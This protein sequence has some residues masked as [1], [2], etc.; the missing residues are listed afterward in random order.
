MPKFPFV[1]NQSKFSSVPFSK[2]VLFWELL[3]YISG[4][5][6]YIL[7]LQSCGRDFFSPLFEIWALFF[8]FCLA[9][10]NGLEVVH[11]YILV[12]HAVPGKKRLNLVP[13]LP[14][15]GKK[16]MAPGMGGS[17]RSLWVPLSPPFTM[18]TGAL[19][20]VKE[21][22]LQRPRD[23]TGIPG[24]FLTPQEAACRVSGFRPG[25][26]CDCGYC[27]LPSLSFPDSK[28]SGLN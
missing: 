24:V 12:P 8:L 6:R 16:V 27:S 5:K 2:T 9:S 23:L 22:E 21:R 17:W 7:S 4:T 25:S 28:R 26:I 13:V 18:Q 19:G 3:L 15:M 14:Q 11:S 10:Y 1:D 20:P